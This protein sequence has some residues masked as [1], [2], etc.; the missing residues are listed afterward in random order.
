MNG[1]Q[2]RDLS[3]YDRSGQ[4]TG[5]VA[6]T[7]SLG[8][9]VS[10]APDGRSVAFVRGGSETETESRLLDPE[11]NQDSRLLATNSTVVWSPDSRR[12]AF[13]GVVDGKPGLYVKGATG[14]STELLVGGGDDRL[15]PSDWSRDGR[16]ITHT[17][18]DP[19]THGDVWLLP[20]SPPRAP[21]PLLHTP[22]NESE[23]T[24]SPDGKWL[25]YASVE[26]S[27]SGVF[28]RSL[29]K[30]MRVADAIRTVSATNAFEPRWRADG[31][32]ERVTGSRRHKLIAVAINERADNPL[33]PPQLLFRVHAAGQRYRRQL[34]SLFALG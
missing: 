12:I 1:Y 32:L 2:E 17:E 15:R 34:I 25:A 24:I 9:G 21:I 27:L 26:S 19:K 33:G 29:G 11:R 7:G 18:V 5:R 23:G 28:L 4:D 13:G 16:Y 30:D 6:V 3:W 10:L 22:A 20:M 31:N 8:D 14:G